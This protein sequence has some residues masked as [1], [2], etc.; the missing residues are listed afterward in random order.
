MRA[1]SNPR[2]ASRDGAFHY[3]LMTRRARLSAGGQCAKAGG[4]FYKGPTDGYGQRRG[5]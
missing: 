2:R 4:L 5:Q 3:A 1:L